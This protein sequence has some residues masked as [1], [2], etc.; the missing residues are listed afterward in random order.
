[1]IIGWFAFSFTAGLVYI[2]NDW[3]DKGSD[4]VTLEGQLNVSV[5]YL[6]VNK[7]DFEL[8]DRYADSSSAV[9]R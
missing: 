9:F 1:L 4:I 5:V 6:D 2:I 8:I 3:K 7:I